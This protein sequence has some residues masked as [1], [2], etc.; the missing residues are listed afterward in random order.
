MYIDLFWIPY[1]QWRLKEGVVPSLFPGPIYLSNI[2]KPRKPPCVRVSTSNTSNSNTILNQ[3][4]DSF[5]N[6]KVLNI[7]ENLIE[8]IEGITNQCLSK[9]HTIILYLRLV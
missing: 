4:V 7:V 5:N 8:D 3:K 9:N 6:A 2:T 1:K